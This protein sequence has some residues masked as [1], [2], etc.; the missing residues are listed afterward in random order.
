ML[1]EFLA[2]LQEQEHFWEAEEPVEEQLEPALPQQPTEHLELDE[3]QSRGA[4]A[5]GVEL[6]QVRSVAQLTATGRRAVEQHE[7]L[8]AAVCLMHKSTTLKLI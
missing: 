8:S 6:A 7:P 1:Y 3:C 5:S 4:G 2:W